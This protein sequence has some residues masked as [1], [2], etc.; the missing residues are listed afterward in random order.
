MVKAEEQ[1]FIMVKQLNVSEQHVLSIF[2]VKHTYSVG[3]I[4][5]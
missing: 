2:L 3:V 5:F 1:K 4:T